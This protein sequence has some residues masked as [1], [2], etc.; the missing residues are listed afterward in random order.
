MSSSEISDSSEEERRVPQSVA[1]ASKNAVRRTMSQ[2]RRVAASAISESDDDVLLD[3]SFHT[4][5]H[6][7]APRS[8]VKLDKL[9]HAPKSGGGAA[10]VDAADTP[11]KA[12]ARMPLPVE[13]HRG[14]WPDS[15]AE[16]TRHAGAQALSPGCFAFFR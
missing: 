8:L 10:G 13:S 14:A 11:S 5:Q 12:A 4:P 1:R 3:D 6:K 9:N 2:A 16:A 7:S 15:N